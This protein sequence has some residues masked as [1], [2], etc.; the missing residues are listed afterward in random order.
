[1]YLR[2]VLNM[3]YICALHNIKLKINKFKELNHT[4]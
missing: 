2:D 3:K 1:M 4:E